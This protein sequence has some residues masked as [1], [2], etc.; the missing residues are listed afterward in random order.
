VSCLAGCTAAG[1]SGPDEQNATVT[2]AVT[3]VPADVL[4]LEI[5]VMGSSSIA[6]R[7]DVMAGQS[8]ILS[9]DGLSPGP[10]SIGA[11]A[12]STACSGARASTVPG[13]PAQ[14]V[15]VTLV[16]GQSAPVSLVLRRNAGVTVTADF[17]D[18]SG[19]VTIAP[20][21]F[22]FGSVLVGQASASA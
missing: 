17:Q 1:P 5:D 21:S 7:F 2:V 3:S 10:A 9:L 15:A 20:G 12:F 18:G 6:R 14:P 4:C 8:S 11:K 13:W 16:G 22:D 19:G